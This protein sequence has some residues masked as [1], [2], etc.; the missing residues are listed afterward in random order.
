[1]FSLTYFVLYFGPDLVPYP[2]PSSMTY[3]VPRY[4]GSLSVV[5]A[6][7]LLPQSTQR[8]LAS[9][10]LHLIPTTPGGYWIFQIVPFCALAA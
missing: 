1:M 8:R 6:P 10:P 3:Y 7:A 4:V 2:V 5:L 9:S